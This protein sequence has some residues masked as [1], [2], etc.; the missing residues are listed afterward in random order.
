WLETPKLAYGGQEETNRANEE[1]K[2]GDGGNKLKEVLP[3]VSSKYGS[4]FPFKECTVRLDSMA[5]D[6]ILSP[7]GRLKLSDEKITTTDAKTAQ[8]SSESSYPMCRCD[9]WKVRSITD[10][11]GQNYFVCPVK[12][13]EGAYNFHQLDVQETI[14]NDVHKDTD[15]DELK[16]RMASTSSMNKGSDSNLTMEYHVDDKVNVSYPAVVMIVVFFAFMELYELGS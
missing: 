13:G 14:R 15:G 7:I 3:H 8:C 10:S 1:Y 2:I 16:A 4:E 11:T 12:K 6:K 9:L 5:Y